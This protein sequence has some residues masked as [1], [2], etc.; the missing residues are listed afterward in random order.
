MFDAAQLLLLNRNKNCS[1]LPNVKPTPNNPIHSVTAMNEIPLSATDDH[2]EDDA[3]ENISTRFLQAVLEQKKQRDDALYERKK[4][5]NLKA[6]IKSFVQS[7]DS[8]ASSEQQRRIL[9]TALK[10]ACDDLA[11]S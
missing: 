7:G 4:I 10:E 9:E 5:D 1:M 6:L 11:A 8:S 2:D 3:L